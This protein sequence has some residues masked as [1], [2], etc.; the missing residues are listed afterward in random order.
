MIFQQQQQQP[1]FLVQAPAPQQ[2]IQTVQPQVFTAVQ[3]SPTRNVQVLSA[4]PQRPTHSYGAPAPQQQVLSSAPILSS[5]Q[6]FTA[7]Q[8]APTALNIYVDGGRQLDEPVVL[9]QVK[10]DETNNARN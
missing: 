6:I 3:S 1:A 9:Q 2:I 10:L 8:P 5:P 7:A 4:P